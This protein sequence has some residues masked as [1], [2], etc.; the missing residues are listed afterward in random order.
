MLFLLGGPERR[1]NDKKPDHDHWLAS[2]Q[3]NVEELKMQRSYSEQQV[4]Q[5]KSSPRCLKIAPEEGLNRIKATESETKQI[6][7]TKHKISR[8]FLK[9]IKV[10]TV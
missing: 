7:R 3:N 4:P 10:I 1:L 2:R 6:G 8:R 5:Q 9:L